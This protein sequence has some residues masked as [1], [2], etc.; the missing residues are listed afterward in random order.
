[1]FG[2]GEIKD[3]IWNFS[4]IASPIEILKQN[5]YGVGVTVATPSISGTPNFDGTIRSAPLIV[6]AND[7]VY[8]S[9]A[10]EV[11]RAFGD[12]KNYQ[13]RVTEEVGIEWIRMGRS[14]P[15]ETTSTADIQIAYWYDF[16]RISAMSYLSPIFKTRF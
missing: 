2:G 1:M 10:L 11:L 5:A 9:V 14:A 12:H 7:V 3:H 6:S 16:K 4:G 15:I 13:V 8:P